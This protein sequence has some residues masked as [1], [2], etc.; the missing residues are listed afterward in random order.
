MIVRWWFL[1]RVDGV[2]YSSCRRLDAIHGN[3][4]FVLSIEFLS[5]HGDRF[6]NASSK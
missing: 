3:S 4:R 2:K 6:E 5:I 1:Y